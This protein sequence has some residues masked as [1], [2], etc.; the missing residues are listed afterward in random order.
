MHATAPAEAQHEGG[1]WQVTVQ[2]R[3]PGNARLKEPTRFVIEA[4]GY[5]VRRTVEMHTLRPPSDQV[6]SVD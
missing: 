1:W 2:S 5:G 4:T 6:Q 3:L